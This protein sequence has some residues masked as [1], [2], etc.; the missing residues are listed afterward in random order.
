MSCTRHFYY[1]P[2]LRKD[3]YQQHNSMTPCLMDKVDVYWFLPYFEEFCKQARISIV[4]YA[5]LDLVYASFYITLYSLVSEESLVSSQTHCLQFCRSVDILLLKTNWRPWNRCGRI[6]WIYF[7]IFRDSH[8]TTIREILD[9]GNESILQQSSRLVPID[10]K[11]WSLSNSR[12]D[13]L[14]R[15]LG[16]LTSF[17][18]GLLHVFCFRNSVE[19]DDATDRTTEVRTWV[20]EIIVK[21]SQLVLQIPNTE[22]VLSEA[23]S[24]CKFGVRDD[25]EFEDPQSIFSTAVVNWMRWDT[26]DLKSVHSALIYCFML[27]KHWIDAVADGITPTIEH[28]ALAICC[29][30][31][32]FIKM[33]G[34]LGVPLKYA[35]AWAGMILKK[36]RYPAGDV[37]QFPC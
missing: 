8:M 32:M 12:P 25:V 35:L 33:G 37:V 23:Y 24:A 29:L 18:Q 11:I 30:S 22:K 26:I 19:A 36:S 28:S 17:L 13:V 5:F 10:I 27:A 34:N 31:A 16:T 6:Y 2:T 9:A 4:S 3:C 7:S 21:I 20:D 1:S 15:N 14:C